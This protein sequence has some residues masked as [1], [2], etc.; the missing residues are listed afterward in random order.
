MCQV[1]DCRDKEVK[2]DLGAD[3]TGEEE[4]G[5]NQIGAQTPQQR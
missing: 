5:R 3:G 2:I 1:G 4:G